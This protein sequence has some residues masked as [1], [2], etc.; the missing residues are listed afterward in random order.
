MKRALIVVLLFCM[1]ISSGFLDHLKAVRAGEQGNWQR[2]NELLQPMVVQQHDNPEL[3]YDA[4]VSS[5]R[6]GAHSQATAY[7]LQAASQAKAS[8][9]LKEKAYFNAGNAYVALNDL[10]QAIV[11]YEKALAINSTNEFAQHNLKRAKEMRDQKKNQNQQD[12]ENKQDKQD[13]GEPE[14]NG[15][16][17]Q[18]NASPNDSEKTD[19]KNEQ[20]EESSESEKQSPQEQQ[21][22]SGKNEKKEPQKES[23]DQLSKSHEQKNQDQNKQG[24]SSQQAGEHKQGDKQAS[25]DNKTQDGQHEA[26]LEKL[27]QERE[28]QDKKA[29]KRLMRATINKQLAGQHGENCW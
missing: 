7:F 5:H 8:N 14:Q 4:G 1:Q 26:W 19:K 28:K 29:T 22:K 25:L 17:K 15:Q 12:Q 20:N 24:G 13:Q 27:L 11:Q 23:A 3:L 6:T 2:A 18:N 16:Q 10:D 9:D 21:K